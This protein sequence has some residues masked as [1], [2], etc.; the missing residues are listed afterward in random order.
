MAINLAKGRLV[1]L[2][3]FR[4]IT[5]F[6][7]V[8]E[9]TRLYT[10]LEHLVNPESFWGKIFTQFSHHPWNGL[11]FWD[12][13]Q[14]YF[15]FIVGVAMAFSLAKRWSQ[16]ASWIDTLKHILTRCGLLLLFGVMLH[17]GYNNKL[18]WELWNVLSQL[19]FTILVAFLIFNLPIRT[20]LI[21][22]FALL[23]ITELAY[24]FFPVSGFNQPFVPDQNFGS[25]MDMMLM[26]KLSGG[27]WVAINCVPT[28]AHTI[29][30]VLAAKILMKDKSENYKLK[31][32][33]L[34]GL[35]GV[36]VGYGMDWT[37]LTPI[38]KRICTSSFV[39]VSGGWCLLTLTFLYWLV[40]ILGFQR[41]TKF[42]TIVG[43]NSIFIYL[44]SETVGHQ[45]F[46][47]FI[48]IF[49][50]GF[51]AM[52]GMAEPIMAVMTA[53]VI[54]LLEWGLCYWLYKHKILI[55]I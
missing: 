18:V 42:F 4:G 38:I 31:I 37:G 50:N 40:D 7:L 21:I 8:A 28:A 52:A 23:I 36:V 46:N 1:S 30:G 24:R 15:M 48:G 2:D 41:W 29:W 20:Q 44:F 12:L 43:M 32:L 53:L 54:L 51:F 25:W 10:S 3:V 11:R 33:G 45:W 27:H 39:I 55:K 22:S 17:C 47:N 26:G 49:T 13:V 9:G 35:I 19:S 16:G 34:A 14:P 6:L 5:M